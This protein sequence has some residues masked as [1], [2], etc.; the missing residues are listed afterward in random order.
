[1]PK[2]TEEMLQEAVKNCKWRQNFQG[3]DI[4]TGDCAPCQRIIESGKCDTL[5]RL[6]AEHKADNNQEVENA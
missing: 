1:M 2:L 6:V 3:I 5:R 4:C